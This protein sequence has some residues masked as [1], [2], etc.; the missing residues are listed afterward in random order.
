MQI[1]TPTIRHDSVVED[2]FGDSSH[3]RCFSECCHDNLKNMMIT[4]F[5]SAKSMIELVIHIME[6]TKSLECLTLDTTRGHDRRFPGMDRCWL[7]NE[8]A[9]VEA[10]KAHIAIQRYIEGRVPAAVNLKVIKPCS[11]CTI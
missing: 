1:G 3:P 8:E 10:E 11:K 7:L 6:R 4:G 5:C 9:L 2:P